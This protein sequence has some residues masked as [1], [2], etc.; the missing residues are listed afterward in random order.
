[1]TIHS[2][3]TVNIDTP[4]WSE[5]ISH[6]RESLIDHRDEAISSLAPGIAIGEFLEYGRRLGELLISDLHLHREV[7]THIERWIDIDEL[8]PSCLLY[9]SSHRSVSQ[10]REYELVISPDEL[11]RPARELSSLVIDIEQTSL[12]SHIL[13]DAWLVDM[14]D[15]LERKS[16]IG[17]I[18]GFPIPDEF[19]FFFILEEVP[20]IFLR[21][22]LA[23]F[24]VGEDIADLSL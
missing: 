14:L 20:A 19:D 9:L 12:Y 2:P 5:E 18:V 17:H 24:E 7:S 23:C 16:D 13:F 6:Q 8:D 1:M 22:W 15:R 3:I 4:I 10:T 11:V 21:K